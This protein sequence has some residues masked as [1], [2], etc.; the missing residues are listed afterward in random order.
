MVRDLLMTAVSVGRIVYDED[1][2]PLGSPNCLVVFC[3]ARQALV[4]CW[5]FVLYKCFII[6]IIKC[7]ENRFWF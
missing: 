6:I 5:R 1:C 3:T 4:L 2:L 7:A